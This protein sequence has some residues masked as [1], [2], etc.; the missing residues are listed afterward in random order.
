[1]FW[2]SLVKLVPIPITTADPEVKLRVPIV[3]A[4][5]TPLRMLQPTTFLRFLYG[6]LID[7]IKKSP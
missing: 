7:A 1:V 5:L 6:V 3:D 2:K 4:S